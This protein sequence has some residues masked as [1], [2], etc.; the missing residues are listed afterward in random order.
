M[1][2]TSGSPIP[3]H[4]GPRSGAAVVPVEVSAVPVEVSVAETPSVVVPVDET[5]VVGPVGPVGVSVVPSV[6]PALID[7]AVVSAVS[8]ALPVPVGVSVAPPVVDGVSVA[9]PVPVAPSSPP[10]LSPQPTTATANTQPVV[11][12][13][14]RP[15]PADRNEEPPE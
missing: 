10:P 13:M 3:P 15:S 9:V 5:S 2:D 6:S 1:Y 7:P 8:E 4:G 14:P 12:R 11:H